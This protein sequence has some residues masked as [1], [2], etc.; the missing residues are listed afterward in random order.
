MS[1]TPMTA[2]EIADLNARF[3]RILDAQGE[4]NRSPAAAMVEAASEA[5]NVV[6]VEWFDQSGGLYQNTRT[7]RYAFGWETTGGFDDQLGDDE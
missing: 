1:R 6:L 7:G 4:D 2:A 5:P 3:E